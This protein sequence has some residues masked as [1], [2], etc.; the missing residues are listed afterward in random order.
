MLQCPMLL[1]YI[2]FQQLFLIASPPSFEALDAGDTPHFHLPPTNAAV[3]LP[4][5]AGKQNI[6]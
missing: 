2:T 4:S 1:L 5:L 3:Q 6:V